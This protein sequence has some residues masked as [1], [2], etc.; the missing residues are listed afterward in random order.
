MVPLLLARHKALLAGRIQQAE[1]R[2]YNEALCRQTNGEPTVAWIENIETALP[3]PMRLGTCI[4]ASWGRLRV[5]AASGNG[6]AVSM[7]FNPCKQLGRRPSILG[8]TKARGRIVFGL[9]VFARRRSALRASN[10]GTIGTTIARDGSSLYP[11]KSR[12]GLPSGLA[13][14]ASK[15]RRRRYNH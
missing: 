3:F 8:G 14:T 4:L 7:F 2:C 1:K 11:N 12:T 5:P 10:N 15:G 13:C 9:F 6:S